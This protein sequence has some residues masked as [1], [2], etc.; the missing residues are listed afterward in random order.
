MNFFTYHQQHPHI[1]KILE[2]FE[3]DLHY[4]IVSELIEGGELYDRIVKAK[5]FSEVQA[6]QLLNQILLAINYMHNQKITHR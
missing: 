2:L 4:Y 3:D 5:V 6:A 1:M